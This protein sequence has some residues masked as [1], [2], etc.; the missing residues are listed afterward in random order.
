MFFM[1]KDLKNWK[2]NKV[3]HDAY[4]GKLYDFISNKIKSQPFESVWLDLNVFEL[5]SNQRNYGRYGNYQTKT[6]RVFC[7]EKD[8]YLRNALNEYINSETDCIIELGSGWGRNILKLSNNEDYKDIDFIAAELSDSGRNITNLFSDVFN[9]NVSSVEFNWYDVDGISSI[10][11]EKQYKNVIIYSYHSIEQI[12]TL[13]SNI[14]IN[15]LSLGMDIKCIHIEPVGFQ[16]DSKSTGYD[17]DCHYNI[18]LKECLTELASHNLIEIENVDVGYF[19]S[20]TTT[21]GRNATLIQ[22]KKKHL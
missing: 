22:W 2:D 15:A 20:H 21:S 7:D 5:G 3:V 14:F 17:K 1:K 16:F 18:N 13:D 12:H 11:S 4:W 6:M 19:Q 8:L 10:L 9:L